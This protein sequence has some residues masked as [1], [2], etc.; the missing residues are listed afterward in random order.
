LG[1]Y[2]FIGGL[3]PSSGG[4]AWKRLPLMLMIAPTA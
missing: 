2:G 3:E 1:A 4:N